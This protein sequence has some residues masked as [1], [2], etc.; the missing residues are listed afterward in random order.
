MSKRRFRI[1]RHNERRD[2]TAEFVRI[3]EI[4]NDVTHHYDRLID[5]LQVES[6]HIVQPMSLKK[7]E[8]IFLEEVFGSKGKIHS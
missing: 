7:Q 2:V 4:C 1:I 3:S 8:Q 6:L 5:R